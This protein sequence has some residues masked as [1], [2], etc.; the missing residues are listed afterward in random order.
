MPFS[1]AFVKG[2]E[3]HLIGESAY[4]VALD[5]ARVSGLLHVPAVNN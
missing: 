4:H 5:T 2:R 1:S 3:I